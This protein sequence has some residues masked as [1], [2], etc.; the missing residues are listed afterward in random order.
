VGFDVVGIGEHSCDEIIRVS[1][2]VVPNSKLAIVARQSRHGGQVS[3]TLATCASLGLKAAYIGALGADVTG[4]AHML[5]LELRGV[6][7]THCVRRRGGVR[8]RTAVIL[9][10]EHTGD[11]TV[12]WDR[13][14]QLDLRAEE[15][16]EEVIA[17]ARAL[18]VDDTDPAA[19]LA[20]ARIARRAGV[21]VTSDFDQIDSTT[22]E[23]L[24]AVSVPILAESMPARLTGDTDPERALRALRRAE[25]QMI[26]VTLGARGA[27]LLVGDRI[28]HAPAF[29]V[30][31][32]DS[33]GAG[34]VFRG[35]FIVAMLRGDSPDQILR[36]ANAAA[37]IACTREGALDGVPTP[38]EISA[39]CRPGL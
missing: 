5:E 12:L 24:A 23:L 36:F 13:D 22:S 8:S 9:V 30:T 34:D 4:A 19:S 33:T 15:L 39:L 14:P 18:H 31:V 29:N 6:D 38:D 37:A 11:R 17:G 35:G 3:T 16:P 25:H 20:A 26:C 32:V 2:A 7:N 27:M 28:H 21:P 1:G 10:D